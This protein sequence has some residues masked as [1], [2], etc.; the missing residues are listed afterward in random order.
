MT[1]PV[2]VRTRDAASVDLPE[3]RYKGFAPGTTTLAAGTR[4]QRGALP[5]PCDIVRDKDVALSMRDGT[6]IYAD[7]FRPATEAPVP[8]VVNWGSLR[9]GRHRLP[10][11]R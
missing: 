1:H 9:E 6:T 11:P 7:V 8:A 3:A 2:P 10:D 4:Y 5:L